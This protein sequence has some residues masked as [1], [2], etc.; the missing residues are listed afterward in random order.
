MA[1]LNLYVPDELLPA[2]KKCAKKAGKSVSAFVTALI[3]KDLRPKKKWSTEFATTFGSWEGKFPEIDRL[4]SQE[5][6]PLK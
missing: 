6:E 4:A 3:E 2:I 5:R 1:Q